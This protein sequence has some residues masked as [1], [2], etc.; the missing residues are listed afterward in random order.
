AI[1]FIHALPAG[2]DT[3][4][5]ERGNNLSSGQRQL[6]GMTRIFALD[7]A[8]LVL[9]EATSSVDAVSERLIQTALERLMAGRTA[10]IIAHRLS[11][12]RNADRIIVLKQ[13]R[14]VEEGSHEVLLARNGE[15]ARLHAIQFQDVESVE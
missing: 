1:S 13:A 14:I 2:F 5:S 12:I 8:I 10:V 7:P 3:R 6:L 15:Y 11:T 4:L 9:D